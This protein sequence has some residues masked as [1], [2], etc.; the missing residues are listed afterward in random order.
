MGLVRSGSPVARL[1]DNSSCIT[2]CFERGW[3]H[4]LCWHFLRMFFIAV[5]SF[6]SASFRAAFH[7]FVNTF[8]WPWLESIF[9][10]LHRAKETADLQWDPWRGD[11]AAGGP[12]GCKSGYETH[13]ITSCS[14]RTWASSCM[15][16]PHSTMVARL[17]PVRRQDWSA[18]PWAG[19]RTL[20]YQVGERI[21]TG[22]Q[23]SE[24]SC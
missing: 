10:V 21:C 15:L 9:E 2:G 14:S 22:A 3:L 23:H 4:Q 20:L 24:G 16:P 13:K 5:T 11:W 19:E 12:Q 18:V 17:T 8:R 6:S 7:P 1:R